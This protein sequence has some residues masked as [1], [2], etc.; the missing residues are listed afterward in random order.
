M[1]LSNI[2]CLKLSMGDLRQ[3]EQIISEAYPDPDAGDLSLYI[4]ASI[5]VVE[6]LPSYGPSP[7]TASIEALKVPSSREPGEQGHA[8]SYQNHC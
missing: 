3:A 7:A 1:I 8:N 5:D 4:F 2:A 6:A